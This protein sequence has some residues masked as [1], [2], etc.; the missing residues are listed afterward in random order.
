MGILLNDIPFAL[1]VEDACKALSTS[2]QRLYD[3]INEG[4]IRSYKEGKRR[5]ISVAAIH[6]YIGE[7]ERLAQQEAA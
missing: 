4:R 2:R 5:F 7:R 1:S 6:D 3:L